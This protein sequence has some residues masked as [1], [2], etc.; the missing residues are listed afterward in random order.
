MLKTA[1]LVRLRPPRCVLDE[2]VLKKWYLK[3]GNGPLAQASFTMEDLL[4]HPLIAERYFFPRP[5][6]PE[7]FYDITAADGVRLR[8]FYFETKPG[9]RTLVHYHGNGEIVV[10]YLYGFLSDMVDL[11][12]N[13]LLVE[14]R[15]YGGSTGKPRLGK[16]LDDVAVVREAMSLDPKK[17]FIYG[18]SLGAIFATE[19]VF[20]EPEVA[21]LILESGVAN[22]Y[23]RLALRVDPKELGVGPEALMARCR[24]RMDHQAKLAA[25]RGPLLL[26]HAAG[27]KLIP[28]EHAQHHLAWA[29]GTRKELVV[30]PRGDHNTI[31]TYN[32]QDMVAHLKT[33]TAD[34]I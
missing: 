26:F 9:A 27:D 12:L 7:N 23:E 28:L 16:M 1:Q 34:G 14:Y 11:G 4:D 10:D 17:T 32:W 13:V 2:V 18:R 8:C 25:F 19:W 15:G 21:G 30:F 20:Q 29:A 31:L 22:P 24:E 5:E 6:E 3:G 33:F